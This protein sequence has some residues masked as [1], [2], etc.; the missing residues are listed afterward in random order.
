MDYLNNFKSSANLKKSSSPYS[1]YSPD[2]YS[3]EDNTPFV[4]QSFDD[5]S[6][7]TV[8]NNIP[9][10]SQLRNRIDL[11]QDDLSDL[12]SIEESASQDSFQNQSRIVVTPSANVVKPSNNVS[13]VFEAIN[14]FVNKIQIKLQELEKS[15]S[16][17]FEEKSNLD[18]QFSELAE[19]HT[20]QSAYLDKIESRYA[21]VMQDNRELTARVNELERITSQQ[22]NLIK[23]HKNFVE[24]TKK[25]L[26][27][28]Y[29]IE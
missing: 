27:S 11:I 23:H 3:R 26:D 4:V 9:V 15:Y 13:Y 20:K 24:S 18:L 14:S 6:A 8:L 1:S 22:S 25:H 19:A 2:D 21:R 7:N 10:N 12:L 29:G 16:A 28:L 17:L 5:V